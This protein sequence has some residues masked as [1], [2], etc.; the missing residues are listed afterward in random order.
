VNRE[1][2]LNY[3]GRS[4]R[5]VQ[6]AGLDRRKASFACG[7][8]ADVVA[9]EVYTQLERVFSTL[10]RKVVH[11]L[12]LGYIAALGKQREKRIRSDPE[13]SGVRLVSLCSK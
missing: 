5:E 6:D 10:D 13:P 12:P 3:A 11:K 1:V 7:E 9:A 2:L 8:I 4:V